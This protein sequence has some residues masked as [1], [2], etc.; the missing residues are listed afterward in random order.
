MRKLIILVTTVLFLSPV[1][2]AQV[3]T[4][5]EEALYVAKKA[6]GDGFYEVSLNLLQ[7][8]LKNFPQSQKIPEANLYIAQCY[9]QQNK[10][11]PCLDQLEKLSSDPKAEAIRD[12][13]FYWTGEVHFAGHDYSKAS[14][15]YQRIIEEFPHSNLLV[16]AYYSRGWCLFELK[17]YRK[18]IQDF[19]KVISD[20]PDDPL[21]KNAQAKK[22]DCL[23][24]LDDYEGLKEEISAF[25]KKYTEDIV[26]KSSIHFFLGEYNFQMNNYPESIQ[27]YQISLGSSPD[28][29][30][31]V[32]SKLR[33]AQ[34]Y[35]ELGKYIDAQDLL[36]AIIPE[37]LTDKQQEELL[38]AKANLFTATEDF[39]A[40]RAV[41][42]DLKKL[43]IHPEIKMQ[44]CLGE[45]KALY[46]SGQY[47]EAIA[48]YQQAQGIA[49]GLSPQLLDELY[50]ELAWAFLKNGQFKEAIDEFQKA[51]SFAS[52]EIVKVTALCQIGDAYQDTEEYERAIEVYDQIL[53]DYPDSFYVDYVQYQLGLACLRSSRYDEAVVAFRTL[54]LNFPK[55]KLK[56]QAIYSLALGLFQQQNYE[57]TQVALQKYMPDLDNQDLEI[58]ALYLL[59]TSLYNL[60]KYSEAMDVFKQVIRQAGDIKISQKQKAEYEIADCFYQ[61]GNEKEALERFKELRAK[62]PDSTLSPEVT[63]WLGGY[64]SRKGEFNLARRYFSTLIRDFPQS[65]LLADGYYALGLLEREEARLDSA[66]VNFEK[67]MEIGS[68]DLVAQAGIAIADI[69]IDQDKLDE[70][71]LAY[72]KAIEKS[73]ALAGL[74]HP[75]IARIYEKKGNF[76][77]AIRFY[78]QALSLVSMKE[79]SNLQFK[80]ARAYERNMDYHRAIEEYLKIPYLYP[81]NS[82]LIVKAYLSSAQIYENQDDW[83]SAKDIYLKV[84][85]MD[86]EEAKYAQERLEWIDSQRKEK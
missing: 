40:A 48:V 76:D 75:K 4:R 54:L 51:A 85:S 2:F 8:F 60:G 71:E 33:L 50:Y 1:L 19:T 84:A 21:V 29:E 68:R 7:R 46:N 6:Y 26:Y 62:Y 10:F 69:L 55:S 74:I 9:F 82:Q 11:I 5:E 56:P 73:P 13:V 20:F 35:L 24:R 52:D 16:H 3:D 61:M 80:I 65:G 66:I 31:S 86:V 42:S 27:Q 59:A 30:I 17:D 81:A 37:G 58:E 63:Y 70:A 12:A 79:A 22:L 36:E 64:Y 53:K 43:T 25:Q 34:C 41:W 44:A 15:F 39:S 38:L 77:Q 67:A 72:Q 57:G 47:S 32:F 78:Q 49:E 45:G 18:A 23:Y 28:Q 14:S 83:L